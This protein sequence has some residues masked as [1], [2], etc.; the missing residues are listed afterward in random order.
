M[1]LARLIAFPDLSR[2]VALRPGVVSDPHAVLLKGAYNDDRLAQ[3]GAAA[4][5]ARRTIGARRQK[6]AI[7][8]SV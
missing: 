4:M 1:G 5:S 6:M 3:T 8:Q 2:D 7:L